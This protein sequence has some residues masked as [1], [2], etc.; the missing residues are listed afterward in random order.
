MIEITFN[1]YGET[2]KARFEKSEYANNR[3]LY[4]GVQTW[5]DDYEYWEPWCDLTVNLDIIVPR[6]EAFLDTNNC[7]PE[8]IRV[9]FEKG[10]AID[11]EV[12]R[13]S[14]FCT[15]PLV[16]FTDEFLNGIFEED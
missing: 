10:Y 3:N 1:A 2:H 6:N 7:T 14:G 13:S 8:L 9:L 12:R 11:T 15:Y 16:R 4:V 5:D